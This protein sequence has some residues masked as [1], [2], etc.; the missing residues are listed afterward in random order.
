MAPNLVEMLADGRS[1]V[2]R[3]AAVRRD[4]GDEFVLGGI[5][6]QCVLQAIAAHF[7]SLG[8]KARPHGLRHTFGT[9]AA[10]VANGSLVLVAQLM[11]HASISTTQRYVGWTPAGADFV[12]QLHRRSG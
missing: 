2:L 8:I 11:G 9:E 6:G 4:D 3:A 5:I 1:H 12:N 10:R 7:R